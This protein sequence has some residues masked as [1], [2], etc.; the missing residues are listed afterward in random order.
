MGKKFCKNLNFA[1]FLQVVSKLHITTVIVVPVW[2][3]G[4]HNGDITFPSDKKKLPAYVVL[5]H[6]WESFIDL[7]VEVPAEPVRQNDAKTGPVLDYVLDEVNIVGMRLFLVTQPSE[8][9]PDYDTKGGGFFG[10][11]LE[12]GM[13]I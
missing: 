9:P 1:Q 6:V 11:A 12:T 7:S 13:P 4:E 5:Q 10:W 2:K 3:N 8:N